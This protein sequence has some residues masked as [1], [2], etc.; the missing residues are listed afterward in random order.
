[1]ETDRGTGREEGRERREEEGVWAR[2]ASGCGDFFCS[3]QL[4]GC[5]GF[6]MSHHVG[7]VLREEKR[8]AQ[9]MG[10]PFSPLR[11]ELWR[12]VSWPHPGHPAAEPSVLRSH[13]MRWL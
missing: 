11:V 3:K 9:E 2:D 10:T 7:G 5:M 6:W 8:K 1:M 13:F 4:A 12:S